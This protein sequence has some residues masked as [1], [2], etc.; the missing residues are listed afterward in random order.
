MGCG[1]LV[2]DGTEVIECAQRSQPAKRPPEPGKSPFLAPE[3]SL[4][5]ASVGD[6]VCVVGRASRTK[7]NEWQILVNSIGETFRLQAR[8]SL[9]IAMLQCFVHLGTKN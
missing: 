4:P 5:V 9:L 3:F 6:S 2:D 7:S 1:Y 8:E